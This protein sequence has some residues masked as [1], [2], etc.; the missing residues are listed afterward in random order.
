M[1]PLIWFRTD[2]RT[3]DNFALHHAC[4]AASGATGN[5]AIALFVISPAEWQQHDWAGIKVD[6][7]RRTLAVLSRDLAK[8]NIPLIIA[9]ASTLAAVPKIVLEVARTHDCTALF[10]NR[11]YEVNESARDERTIELF[12]GAGLPTFAYHDQVLAPP[13]DVRT[14]TG[15]FY[16]VFTPFKKASYARML[17]VGTP[18]MVPAPKKLA[19]MACAPSPIPDHIEGFTS[20]VAPDRWPAGEHAAMTRLRAFIDTHASTYKAQRDL[21]AIDAT[22][23]LSPYLNIGAISVRQCL[24]AAIS[25]NTK[26]AKDKPFDTGNDGIVHWISEL[27]W[28]EFYIHIMV[29]FP[30][31]CKHRAF[32]PATEAIEW[33]DNDEH[34]Q[35]WCEG[36]TGVPIV[37]AGMRQLIRDGWMHNRVRMITAMY[38][39][40]NLFIDW[41]RGETFFMQHLVDGFLASNNGG[42]QWSASTGT[43]AA[44]YFRVFNPVSQSQK[45]DPTGDYIRE[46]VP[47]LQSLE[48][49]AIHE[50]WDLA[51][52]ARQRINYPEPIVDLSKSRAHAIEAFRALKQ[53]Q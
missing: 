24:H 6:F 37:D 22:S 19:T 14:G 44:P 12:K 40:K 51:P 49:D 13:G 17:N 46:F 5:S 30:R 2:L 32:Q 36:R 11:E 26:H 7:L 4:A 31:V 45:C 53:T 29:G 25:A 39:T 23:Q 16:T 43:D 21:P 28:R 20:P 38:L 35:A 3:A 15:G 41:R 33:N 9:N 47:E 50:P 34:F 10:F 48:T 52:L 8:L 18:E 1:R 42:W 27:L